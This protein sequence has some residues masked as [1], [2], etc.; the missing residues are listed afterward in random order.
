MRGSTVLLRT[1]ARYT[2]C[3]Q[4]RG[5]P[6]PRNVFQD[7]FSRAAIAV[8]MCGEVARRVQ[9]FRL[10][11]VATAGQPHTQLLEQRYE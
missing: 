8:G 5:R 6:L 10:H 7:S 4:S 9:E 11:P 2:K 3:C 1:A